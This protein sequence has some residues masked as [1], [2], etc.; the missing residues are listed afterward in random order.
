MINS[1][2]KY[3]VLFIALNFYLVQQLHAQREGDLWAFGISLIAVDYY[4]TNESNMGGMFNE[5][6]NVGDHWNF[7]GL[8]GDASRILGNNF[9]LNGSFTI[10]EIHNLGDNQGHNLMYYAFDLNFQ[11]QFL[12]VRKKFEPYL[13]GGGGYNYVEYYK[14]GFTLNTGVGSNFWFSNSW[15]VNLQAGFKYNGNDSDLL[16]HFFYAFGVIFRQDSFYNK[17]KYRWRNGL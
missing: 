10:N 4:P 7:F 8:K 1:L 6:F 2:R 14:G 13:Y 15:G 16:S 5:L 9:M 3:L 12:G 17:N 11:Y